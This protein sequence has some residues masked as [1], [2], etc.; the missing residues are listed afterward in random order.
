MK[1]D[2]PAYKTIENAI[3]PHVFS[4]DSELQ[5]PSIEVEKNIVMVVA[6]HILR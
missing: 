4:P 3:I 5:N 2:T 6:P 1:K